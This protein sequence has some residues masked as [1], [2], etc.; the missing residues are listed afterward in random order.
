MLL[1]G[2][3]PMAR[4]AHAQDRLCFP[5]VS[6]ITNCIDGRFRQYWQ[7]NG[8]LPVFGYPITA[9]A[10]ERNRDTGQTYLTQWFERNRFELHPENQPPYGVLLG[11]LGNDRLLQ[12]GRNWQSFPTASPSA[13][14]YFP[15]TQHAITHEPF[16]NYW[17]THGLEFD[18]RRGVSFAESLALFGYPISEPAMET[19]LSGD[20]VL[21]QWFER[22][23]FEW[24]PNNP[25]PFRVLLG[26]LGNEVRA[27]MQPSASTPPIVTYVEQ[28]GSV[29]EVLPNGQTSTRIGTAPTMGRVLDAVRAGNQVV[30]LREQGLQSV[31]MGQEARTI[32]T[33]TQSNARF[34]ALVAPPNSNTI[35][36]SYTRDSNTRDRNTPSGFDGIAGV[37]ENGT[38]ARKV[39][40]AP[41]PMFVLG[42]SQ[43]NRAMYVI[44]QGG[45][46]AFGQILAVALSD[47]SVLARLPFSGEN[48]VALSPNREM[49]AAAT[50]GRDINHPDTLV[51]YSLN[52]QTGAPR[53]ALLPR[54]GWNIGQVIWARDSRAVYALAAPSTS[55][56]TYEL[57]RFDAA[58]LRAELVA[59][60]LPTDT[61]LHSIW[62]DGR[63]L[64]TQTQQGVLLVDLTNGRTQSYPLPQEAVVA[65]WQ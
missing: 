60:G 50:R 13:A 14:H 51:F 46:P 6:G 45:D 54:P 24:H 19:N 7:Q 11:L 29:Y 65:R 52:N 3:L 1:L 12:Q 2:A 41:N 8:G 62:S 5:N 10:N 25:P 33:F 63:W 47:G 53:N 18:G 39:R 15:Q 37:I 64:L 55:Q 44:D 4:P 59:S 61:R 28:N 32:A 16:W 23:R 21:T 49:I 35:I 17:S 30:L 43:D 27:G 42:L 38:T 20:T 57:W 40:E 31:T 56:P 48:G 9:A 22:A 58:T 34:G 26:L 36:Y